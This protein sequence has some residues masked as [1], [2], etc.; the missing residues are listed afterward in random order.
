M[1]SICLP[2]KANSELV[3]DLDAVLTYPVSLQ[4]LQFVSRR[5]SKVFQVKGILDLIQFAESN[6][7]DPLP[8][9]IS[10]SF[11]EFLCIGISEALNHTE[12]I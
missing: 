2:F 8:A 12:S 6:G 7:A 4:R 9:L 5:H 3:I 10:A 1:R 11:K